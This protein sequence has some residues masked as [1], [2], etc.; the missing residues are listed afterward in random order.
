M[1][2]IVFLFALVLFSCSEDFD[3]EKVIAL[4]MKLVDA[5]NNP[6][7]NEKITISTLDYDYYD[8]EHKPIVK[9]TDS[10]GLVNFKMFQPA[11]NANLT[12][13]ANGLFLP[14]TIL[15]IN[16][17]ISPKYSLD[18]GTIYIFKQTDLVD[19]GILFSSSNSNKI[20]MELKID[21]IKY[22]EFLDASN[23]FNP[24]YGNFQTV[25]QLK[26]NQNF[27]L[28]YKVK[29]S[30]TGNIATFNVPLSVGTTP[31]THTIIY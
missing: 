13:D 2:K 5:N 20:V 28:T 29:D 16:A 1:K 9:F 7:S 21:A 18:F 24:L 30:S 8:E 11:Q 15:N 10:Q 3:G 12:Y 6:L 22:D 31:S 25:Y 27:T 4:K 23:N 17:L 19:F 14:F 26:K